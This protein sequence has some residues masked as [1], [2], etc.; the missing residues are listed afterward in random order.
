MT[1][2]LLLASPRFSNLP[3]ALVLKYGFLKK[4]FNYKCTFISWPFHTVAIWT[5]TFHKKSGFVR[6]ILKANFNSTYR[7]NPSLFW[8][9]NSDLLYSFF[10]HFLQNFSNPLLFTH[11]CCYS[12]ELK[13]LNC[14]CWI[15][16]KFKHVNSL[17]WQQQCVKSSEFEKFCKK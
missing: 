10:F 15:K 11:W 6:V 2:T 7:P 4:S 3:T 8:A 16:S 12:K 5:F 13:Y 9:G 17:E 14:N 1:T